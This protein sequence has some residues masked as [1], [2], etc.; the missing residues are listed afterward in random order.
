MYFFVVVFFDT[1][2]IVEKLSFGKSIGIKG[3]CSNFMVLVVFFLGFDDF[4]VFIL[5]HV[6]HNPV[7]RYFCYHTYKAF[8]FASHGTF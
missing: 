8:H 2:P 7:L 1:F 3:C 5:E 6:A 4:L